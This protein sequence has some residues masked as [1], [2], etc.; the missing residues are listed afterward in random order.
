METLAQAYG[1]YRKELRQDRLI[2]FH[3]ADKVL[4]RLEA[5]KNS[6]HRVDP[7]TMAL[8][9]SVRADESRRLKQ[10]GA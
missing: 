10:V 9:I 6:G 1:L 3:K 2:A 8:A 4:T 5:M 7:R